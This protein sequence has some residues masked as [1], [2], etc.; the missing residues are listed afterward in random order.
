ML[1]KQKKEMVMVSCMVLYS[2]PREGR[3]TLYLSTNDHDVY[4]RIFVVQTYPEKHI[5]KEQKI[6]DT[7]ANFCAVLRHRYL[8]YNSQE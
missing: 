2:F 6:L 3:V 5:E 4:I 1:F 8:I 7:A